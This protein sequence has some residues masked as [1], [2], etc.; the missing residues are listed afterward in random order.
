M[1]LNLQI[2]LVSSWDQWI[3]NR[4]FNRIQNE[5]ADCM[6]DVMQ[7]HIIQNLKNT[8]FLAVQADETTDVSIHCQFVGVIRHIDE[9]NTLQE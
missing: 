8:E 3:T 6:L 9:A 5:L 2:T 1:S 4:T 7:G